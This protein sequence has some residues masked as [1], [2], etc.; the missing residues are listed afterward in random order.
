LAARNIRPQV[1]IWSTRCSEFEARNR[2][3]VLQLATGT[4]LTACRPLDVLRCRQARDGAAKQL[5]LEQLYDGQCVRRDGC[6]T[7]GDHSRPARRNVLR[8]WRAK[9]H[10]GARLVERWYVGWDELWTTTDHRRL[11]EFYTRMFVGAPKRGDMGGM[12]VYTLEWQ[13]AGAVDTRYDGNRT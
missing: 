5:L 10:I 2:E 1:R 13:N 8:G 9:A 4:K 11:P 3:T 12:G 6:W 7:N